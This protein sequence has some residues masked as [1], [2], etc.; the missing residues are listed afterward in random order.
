MIQVVYSEVG[1]MKLC[2]VPRLI[3]YVIE[4]VMESRM[5]K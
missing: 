4:G 3:Q 2:I 1:W 5:L